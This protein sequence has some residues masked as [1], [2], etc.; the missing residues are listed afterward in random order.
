MGVFFAGRR[1][2]PPQATETRVSEQLQAKNP[3]SGCIFVSRMK[4]ALQFIG[5]QRSGSNLLRVMLNQ[6][7]EI[8]APHPPHILQVMMPL[9]PMYGNLEDET[10]F[11]QLIDD[12]C[13]LVE[14]NPVNWELQ[15]NRDAIRSLCTE[16]SLPQVMCAVYWTKAQAKNAAWW[17]CKSMAS[18]HY[19]DEIEEAGIHPLYLFMY[20][21]GRDVACSFRKAVVGEKHI[22]FLA[23]QWKEEQERSLALQQQLGGERVL[24]VRYEDFIADAE[25]TLK[26]ICS[27]MNIA[28]TPAMLEYAN[29]HESKITASS[30]KM[31]SNLTQPLLRNN[32]NKYVAELSYDDLLIF[33]SV[34]GD[35]LE[36]LGYA[37]EIPAALRRT[38]TPEEISTFAQLNKQWKA[39]AKAI[40]TE[41][42]SKRKAQDEFIAQLHSRFA[43]Y[44]KSVPA[45]G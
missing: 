22:Y 1:G 4:N 3:H 37:C 2:K 18:I 8:S 14:K 42:M 41:D 25:A 20:R 7:P 19:A 26:R 31:W 13:T 38:F 10:A 28:Y 34:A 36:K 35:T 40:S 45:H 11:A 27:G 39:E 30:G 44:E 21:D 6:H 9:L 43:A 33:E 29:A 24:S 5:T 15:F 12:A 17:C 16:H 32:S 23:K